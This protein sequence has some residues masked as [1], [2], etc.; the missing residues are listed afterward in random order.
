MAL[1]PYPSGRALAGI[2]PKKSWAEPHPGLPAVIAKVAIPVNPGR[3]SCLALAALR[4]CG[5]G[6]SRVMVFPSP[7]RLQSLVTPQDTI[8]LLAV[9]D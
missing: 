1:P 3:L 9:S 5:A 6:D 7:A 8:A 4:L 2:A